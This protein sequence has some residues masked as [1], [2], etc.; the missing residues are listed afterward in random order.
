M[1]CKCLISDWASDSESP[2][3]PRIRTYFENMVAINL[4]HEPSSQESLKRIASDAQLSGLLA[5]IVGSAIRLLPYGDHGDLEHEPQRRQLEQR[6]PN[7]L[8]NLAFQSS[9]IARFL[10]RLNGRAILTT[11]TNPCPIQGISEVWVANRR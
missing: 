8:L 5:A 2:N 10:E 11:L 1:R 9:T 4:F 3:Y 7:S 6:T